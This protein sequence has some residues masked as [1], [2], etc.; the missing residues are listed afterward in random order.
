MNER[1]AEEID[2]DV[3]RVDLRR[4]KP[5]EA[6]SF[7]PVKDKP[8]I[9]QQAVEAP[10]SLS[11]FKHQIL[12]ESSRNPG[13]ARETTGILTESDISNLVTERDEFLLRGVSNNF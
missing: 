11:K 4:I 2:D 6:T 10:K 9:P 13:L 5:A 3:V 1:K 7:V 8:L 12:L